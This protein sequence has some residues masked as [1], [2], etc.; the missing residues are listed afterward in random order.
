MKFLDLQKQFIALKP[1]ME[2]AIR[3]TLE[4]SEFILGP[5]VEKFEVAMAQFCGV[6]YAIGVNSGTDALLASL[7]ALGIGKGDEVITTPFSFFAT[8]EVILLAGAKPVFVDIDPTTFNIDPGSIEQRITKRTRVLIPVHLFGLPA[9]MHEILQIARG[10]RLAVIEDAAQALGS[11]YQGKRVCS[12][13]DIGCVSFFPSKNLG[14]YGDGG[15]VLTNNPKLAAFVRKWRVHGSVVKYIHDFVGVCSRLDALQAAILNV[16]LPHLTSWNATRAKKALLYTSLLRSCR[17]VVTPSSVPGLTHVYNQYTIRV[18]ER[19][20]QLANYLQRK[21]IPTA[22]YYPL[23]LHLQPALRHLG[24]RRGS[25]PLA[26]RAAAEV[27]S[28]PIY[29]ELPNTEIRRSVNSILQ[30]FSQTS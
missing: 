16:K 29:P 10:Y 17:S 24:Y 26:E 22:I 20:D 23:P 6:R 30:F 2:K 7:L 4:R 28:L 3:Q 19:R 12:L 21:G 27:L 25:L 8:A 5:T 18:K 11:T 9:Q 1:E 15:V 14:A 13:G